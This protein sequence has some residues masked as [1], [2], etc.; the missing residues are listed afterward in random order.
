MGRHFFLLRKRHLVDYVTEKNSVKKRNS[1][2][3]PPP[4]NASG[5]EYRSPF[6]GGVTVQDPKNWAQL[7]N[8][9]V[10][11]EAGGD[12]GG[13]VDHHRVDRFSFFFLAN[14]WQD[15]GKSC[16][17][18]FIHTKKKESFDWMPPPHSQTPP[19]KNGWNSPSWNTHCQ[20]RSRQVKS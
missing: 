3:A 7:G 8:F 15:L 13:A 11:W 4:P 20:K 14:H 1:V 12:W 9:W 17:F 19:K 16:F 6:L 2:T 18:C 10:V 5:D